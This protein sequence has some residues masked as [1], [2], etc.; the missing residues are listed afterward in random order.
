MR[1]VPVELSEKDL[2]FILSCI[3]YTRENL[4]E[5]EENNNII[6]HGKN[7]LQKDYNPL[8]AKLAII[9]EQL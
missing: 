3:E 1:T 7:F 4:E 6:L 9:E 8:H 2:S 5:F